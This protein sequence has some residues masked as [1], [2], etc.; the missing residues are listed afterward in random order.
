MKISISML[1]LI[2]VVIILI[3]FAALAQGQNR[4]RFGISAK[5][6][7]INAVTGTVSVKSGG[8]AA[9]MLT[10]HDDLKSGDIVTTGVSS[11]VEVLLNPGSYLRLRNE[12]SSS[13]K[14]LRCTIC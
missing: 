13:W 14:I 12:A 7:G 1:R 5:A 10:S 2:V 6:G 11:Q 4:E 8:D 3:A 9:R